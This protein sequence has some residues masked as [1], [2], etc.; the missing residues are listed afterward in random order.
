MI[1]LTENLIEEVQP[2]V[3]DKSEFEKQ[4]I[5]KLKFFGIFGLSRLLCKAQSH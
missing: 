4:D 2:V 1:S 5:S 3:A